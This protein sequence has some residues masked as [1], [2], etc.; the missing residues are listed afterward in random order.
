M[1]NN[2]LILVALALFAHGFP[3]SCSKAQAS[4]PTRIGNGLVVSPYLYPKAANQ[5]LGAST[6]K[7]D[8]WVDDINGTPFASISLPSG[9][10]TTEYL[11]GDKS[12]QTLNTAAVPESGNLYY[13]DVRARLALSAGAPISYDSGTGV[14]SMPAG[15]SIAD[16]YITSAAFSTFNGKEPAIAP[17]ASTQYFRGDKTFQTLNTAAVPE[18]GNLYYTDVR[19]RAAL[20]ATAPVAYDNS[21]GV[22][23]MPAGSSTQNGYVSTS[24][25]SVAGEKT[26]ENAIG[27]K[28]LSSTPSNPS[29]GYQ[30]IYAKNDGKV[31]RLQSSGT[32]TELGAGG[33]GGGVTRISAQFQLGADNNP[34]AGNPFTF[35]VEN[36]DTNSAYN[37]GTGLFTVPEGGQYLVSSAGCTASVS[38]FYADVYVN[39]TKTHFLFHALTTFA[40]SGAAQ[41][42]VSAGDTISVRPNASNALGFSSGNYACTTTITKLTGL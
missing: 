8:L 34:G 35:S 39:S 37:T 11:R 36:W 38:P 30:K 40:A 15:S 21:T 2:S 31:Y 3:P 10:S 18:S 16:G 13:T 19:A 25:Q 6:L 27:L 41:V 20:S 24:A 7:W 9:G 22:I 26:H 17:G 28:E 14:F 33:G 32:E 5:E 4:I 23:S 42:A 12:W 1:K 29:A